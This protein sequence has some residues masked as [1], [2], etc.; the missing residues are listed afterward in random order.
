MYVYIWRVYIVRLLNLPCI[1]GNSDAAQ[2]ACGIVD[3]TEI[4]ENKLKAK[5]KKK[6]LKK[7]VSLI[8]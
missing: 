2:E 6:R 5:K 1:I 4:L 8:D 3:E 7:K